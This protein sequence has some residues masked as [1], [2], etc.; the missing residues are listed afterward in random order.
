MERAA[1]IW[2]E[3]GLG[4]LALR[5]PWHCYQLGDWSESWSEF[6][7]NA[8]RG[9]WMKNGEN[10]FARRRGGLSPETPVRLVETPAKPR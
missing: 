9:D 6:A 7:V 10:T 8:V 5:P 3:L 4:P 2:R 1:Q